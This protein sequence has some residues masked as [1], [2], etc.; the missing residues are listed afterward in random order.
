MFDLSV[1]SYISTRKTSKETIFFDRGIPDT[2]AYAKRIRSAPT[3][4]MDLYA[5]NHATS[6][7]KLFCVL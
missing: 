2:L 6:Y 4:E 3:A 5:S 1:E 7:F